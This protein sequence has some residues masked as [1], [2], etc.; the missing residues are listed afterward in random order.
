MT[1]C[2]QLFIDHNAF[3]TI[4]V[5]F[6]FGLNILFANLSCRNSCNLC[7]LKILILCFTSCKCEV[8]KESTIGR[9]AF[10]A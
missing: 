2:V 5:A 4:D 1:A 7:P 10:K 9:S 6:L 3:V 8:L